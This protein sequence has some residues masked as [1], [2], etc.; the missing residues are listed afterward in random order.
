MNPKERI[1]QLVAQLT[2]ANY[3]YYVL[4]NPLMLYIEYEDI[5]TTLCGNF[6]V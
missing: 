2:E 6:R 5:Q 3:R 4:D 1:E